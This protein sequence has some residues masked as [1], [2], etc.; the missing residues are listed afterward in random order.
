M[1]CKNVIETPW[2]KATMAIKTFNKSN[3][4][5]DFMKETE[6]YLISV[7]IPLYNCQSSLQRLLKSIVEQSF[8]SFEIVIVNDGSTDNSLLICEEFAKK[9]DNI[10]ILNK[11]NEGVALAREYGIKNA[12]GEYIIHADGDDWVE[13]SMLESMYKKIIEDD[14]DI[15]IS[16]FYIDINQ[17]S[18]Y[19]SQNFD[20]NTSIDVFYEIISGKLMGSLWNK[21]IRRDLYDDNQ[22]YFFK[23]INYF[24]DVLS[25]A[26]LM[27]CHNLKIVH[28]N[29]AFYHYVLNSNSIT[30][31][32]TEHTYSGLVRYRAQLQSLLPKEK[33]FDDYIEEFAITLF[34]IAFLHGF[35]SRDKLEKEY[36]LIQSSVPKFRKGRRLYAHK[37]Y[38][39]GFTKLAKVIV[40]INSYR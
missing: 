2:P 35:I 14:A 4:N 12:N 33:R 19:K 18:E 31:N 36:K 7:I 39:F 40:K 3:I 23:G 25:L 32:I 9:Y 29:K 38:E 1:V 37:L 28:L 6:Q 11:K 30:H 34:E 17:K 16:D 26:Y 15:L 13:P 5:D 27:L 21:L 22:L 8:N 24:E 20:C 10:R